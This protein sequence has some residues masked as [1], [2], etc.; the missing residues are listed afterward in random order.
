MKIEK[1]MNNE[2]LTI[3]FGGDGNIKIETLTEFLDNYKIL[4]YQIN[5]EF[6][7]SPD[8][9]II[10]VSPP[11]NGSF[12]IKL[13]PKYKDLLVTS[14]T[15]LVVST[16]SGLIIYHATKEE[17]N[18]SIEEVKTLLE[19]HQIKD[20]KV[21]QYVYNIYQNTGTQ[22]KINQTFVVVN[23]DSNIS[24]LKIERDN[25]E[26]INVNQN[27]ISELLQKTKIIETDEIPETDIVS[28]E[29]IL[30]IKTIH[31]EGKGKWAFIFRGYPIKAIIKDTKFLE[32]LSE[33]PF[34]KGDSL[35]VILSRKR[36]FDDELQTYIIDQNSYAIENVLL[37]KSKPKNNQKK[38]DM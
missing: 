22:Q 13:S 4:L 34:M 14:L 3:R 33:E 31:F 10:E 30:I 26:I 21:N 16:L 29:Q 18:S 1:D 6:G 36:T 2:Q 37:H 35:K 20:P 12:K 23:N 11:E 19:K 28:D 7:Y 15:T 17:E 24:G 8:D 32:R 38:L 5:Q 9:L 27:E 25:E